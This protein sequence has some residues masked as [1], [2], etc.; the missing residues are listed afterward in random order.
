MLYLKLMNYLTVLLFQL[1]VLVFSVIIHEVSHGLMALRLGDTTA[2]DAGRLTLNP[3]KHL[4]F[5]GSFIVPITLFLLSGGTLV[6]GWA[7]PVPYN[8]YNLKNPKLSAA[9]IGLAGPL[10]NILVALI[11]GLLIRVPLPAE[12]VVPLT[13]M[14]FF[15][16]IVFINVL[17]AVFNLVPIPPLDGSN[18]L[19]SLMPR[20]LAAIQRF[21]ERYGIFILIF[22]IFFG[23][24]FIFPVVYALYRLIVG[25]EVAF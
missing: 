3:L 10:S 24:Q 5:F 13:L 22:F 18:I 2:R 21:L 7:K 6:L 9:L 8:P 11:F 16:F 25:G 20:Q 15:N 14:A 1:F 17:L 23:F 4:D 19:F 12:L